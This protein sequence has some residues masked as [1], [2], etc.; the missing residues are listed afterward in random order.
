MHPLPPPE[1]PKKK[2]QPSETPRPPEGC[3]HRS[4]SQACRTSRRSPPELPPYD[5][6]VEM[7]HLCKWTLGSGDHC[8]DCYAL[9]GHIKTLAEWYRLNLI[10]PIHMHCKCSLVPVEQE[11]LSMPENPEEPQETTP[12]IRG[13]R[14]RHR[15]RIV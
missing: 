1:P 14:R 4:S 12:N 10:P 11:N 2:P 8:D 15:C 5:S 7:N 9:S 6:G 13:F 3:R